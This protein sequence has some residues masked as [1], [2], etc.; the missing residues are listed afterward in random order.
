MSQKN[1]SSHDH[2]RF[3]MCSITQLDCTN[4]LDPPITTVRSHILCVIKSLVFTGSLEMCDRMKKKPL[5]TNGP[6][7]CPSSNHE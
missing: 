2:N 3:L 7:Q 4:E 1:M 6:P 5:Y